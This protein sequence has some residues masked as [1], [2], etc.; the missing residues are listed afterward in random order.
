MAARKDIRPQQAFLFIPQKLMINEITVRN[1]KLSKVID[2]H[3]EIFKHHFDS[4]YLILIVFLWYEFL[5]EEKSFW[6]PYF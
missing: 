2:S 6:Y 3:Q 5:K 1:S 4:E